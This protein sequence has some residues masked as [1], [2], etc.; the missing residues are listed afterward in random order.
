MR[1]AAA[2][3]QV[4]LTLH[5][6]EQPK[7]FHPKQVHQAHFRSMVD[8]SRHT[9]IWLL[10]EDISFART[11]MTALLA[12]R[13]C[14]FEGGAP[15]IVAPTV[16]QSTQHFWPANWIS[17]APFADHGWLGGCGHGTGGT[18]WTPTI[19]NVTCIDQDDGS[20]HDVSLVRRL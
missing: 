15:V 20:V 12:A 2:I 4:P 17:W 19:G 11:D 14:A 16:R 6:S 3:L 8:A 1:V 18:Q 10:D 5:R 13:G 7:G 9:A